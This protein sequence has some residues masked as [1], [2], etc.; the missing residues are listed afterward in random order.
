MHAFELIEPSWW[1]DIL[2]WW[3]EVQTKYEWVSNLAPIFADIFVVLYPLFLLG[4]YLYAIIKKKPLFKQWAIYILISTV[5]AVLINI[6][7]QCFFYKERPIVVMNHVET[8]ETLLHQILPSS[9]FPSDH[10]VVSMAVAMATLLWWL[11]S[12]KKTFLWGWIVFIV[13]SFVMT[14]CRILTLVHRPSDIIA[15][16]LLWMFVPL[17]LMIRPIRYALIK[18]IINPI[19]RFEQWIIDSLFNYKQPEV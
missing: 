15:W 7:I 3:I 19:I 13:V 2:N 4:V 6:W 18:Y 12:K 16:L 14:S 17:I 9:S 8:E 5:I 1:L 11:Y 10:A